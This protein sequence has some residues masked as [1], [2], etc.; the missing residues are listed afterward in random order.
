MDRDRQRQG[1]SY[2]YSA[3]Q[4][5]PAGQ[6]H[7]TGAENANGQGDMTADLPSADL[8]VTSSDA[9]PGGVAEYH[10]G[11]RGTGKGIGAVHSE[12]TTSIVPGVSV[13]DTEI[14]VKPR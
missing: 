8:V 2:T 5:D 6:D 11:V 1:I 10:V 3:P 9:V 7:L 14:V 12:M 13:V 4:A